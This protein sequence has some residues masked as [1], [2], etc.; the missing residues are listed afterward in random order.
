MK[1]IAFLIALFLAM[2][3]PAKAQFFD[4]I[5]VGGGARYSRQSAK[6]NAGVDVIATKSVADWARLRVTA[7]VLGFI[8]NGFDRY[9]S[10]TCGVMAEARPAYVFADFGLS[11]NPSAK[12]PEVGMA[13]DCGVGIK[14]ALT[15]HL[16]IYSELG[17]DRIVH[18]NLL[19]STASVKAG[20]LYYN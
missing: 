8:P 14:V 4:G 3:L 5:E 15:S 9:G 10:V 16:K 18:G 1:K 12:P 2:M 19:K 7:S 6:A 17:I 11:M 13:F 20:L